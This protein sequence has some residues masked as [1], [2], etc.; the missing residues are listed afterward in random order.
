VGTYIKSILFHTAPGDATGQT[1]HNSWL[2]PTDQRWRLSDGNR[3]EAIL[4]GRVEV[5]ASLNSEGNAEEVC[6]SGVSP[7]KLW[8][9]GLPGHDSRKR[10]DGSLSQETYVRVYIPVS[11]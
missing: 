11:K 7:S 2:R 3:D 4:F 9:D 6:N 5:P 1:T 8:L 10:I